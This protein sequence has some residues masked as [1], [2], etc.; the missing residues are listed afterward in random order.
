MSTAIVGHG[1]CEFRRTC[2][3]SALWLWL[4]GVK[5]DAGSPLRV[6]KADYPGIGG[7]AKTMLRD[8]KP[9]GKYSGVCRCYCKQGEKE[10]T[11]DEQGRRFAQ[12]EPPK[13][14]VG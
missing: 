4:R 1:L 7:T 11:P 2:L 6:A 3:V 5:T 10:L 14:K 13:E 12:H 9:G 8:L